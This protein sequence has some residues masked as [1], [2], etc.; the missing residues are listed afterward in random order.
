MKTLIAGVPRSGKTTLAL[1]MGMK[2]KTRVY[3]TDDL[4]EKHSWS[5]QSD[6]VACWFN[7][8][9]YIIEGVTI[10]R[11]LRKWLSLCKGKP[12]DEIIW[13]AT[14]RSTLTG[15]LLSMAKGC[16]SIMNEIEDELIKRGVKIIVQ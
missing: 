1:E 6:E 14:P 7:M 16:I 15:G 10:P 3:H 11:A 8:K 12:C 4:I 9:N 2:S 5:I 13:L